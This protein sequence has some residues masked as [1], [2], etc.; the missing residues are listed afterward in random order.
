MV[1]KTKQVGGTHY[2]A[3]YG[4]WHLFHDAK[5][6]FHVATAIKYVYRWRSKNGVEDLEKALTYIYRC[7]EIGEYRRLN[8]WD[9]VKI[10]F[11]YMICPK[12]SLRGLFLSAVLQISDV[13][14]IDNIFSGQYAQ[15]IHGIKNLIQK[16][17]EDA[18]HSVHAG[19]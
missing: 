5:V 2:G 10:E 3:S 4:P 15:A 1:D 11:G 17:K 7:Q 8:F 6:P 19:Y 18:Q 14:I 9:R 12:E 13:I 16:R